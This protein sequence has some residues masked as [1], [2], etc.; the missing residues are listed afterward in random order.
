MRVQ[1]FFTART[2]P[3]PRVA[4]YKMKLHEERFLDSETGQNVKETL[5]LELD[6]NTF[7]YKKLRKIKKK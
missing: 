3:T 7:G 2:N 4:V 5:Y 1:Q 6:Y